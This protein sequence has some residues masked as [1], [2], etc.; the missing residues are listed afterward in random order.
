VFKLR[1]YQIKACERIWDAW[2]EG[3]RRPAVV[4]PTGA[5][6]TVTFVELI[7]QFVAGRT[8]SRAVV[9]VH[10]EE[11]AQQTV[12]KIRVMMPGV[13]VGVVKAD[14]DETHTRVV[15]CSTQTLARKGRVERLANVGLV[16]VDECHHYAAKTWKGVLERFGC[17][18][19]QGPVTVGFTATLSRGDNVGLGTV[20]EDVVHQRSI[21]AMIRDGHLC[22]LR[23]LSVEVDGLDLGTVARK[24]GGDFADGSLSDALEASGAA[25]VIADAYV[26]HAGNGKGIM[27]QGVV[28]TPTVKFARRMVDA[29][30][31]AGVS[32]AVITG[33]TSSEDRALIYKR[34]RE[35]DV[36][37]LCNCMVLTEGWDAPWAEVAVIARP[38]KS[39]GLYTQMVGRVL[40]THPGKAGALVLDVCG[41]AKNVSLCTVADLSEDLPEIE[42]GETIKE[43]IERLEKLANERP[44]IDPKRVVASEVD[45]FR[46]AQGN[47]L[48][49]R[50]GACFNQTKAHT[51]FLWPVKDADTYIVGRYRNKES[52]KATGEWLKD[53]RWERVHH[54]LATPYPMDFAVALTDDMAMDADP[55][56][57]GRDAPWRRKRQPPTEGQIRYASGLGYTIPPN[58]GADKKTVDGWTRGDVAQMISIA[59]VGND[60]HGRG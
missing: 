17:F 55:S 16:V 57:A 12:D 14:R 33:E 59:V 39:S 20:W 36:R 50:K 44:A 26:K 23:S 37:V 6:K 25:N 42:D 34:Y 2:K 27:R 24:S 13:S 11:L 49:T 5:G 22:D 7:R 28:F 9:L 29:F 47:W 53:G 3:L 8:T 38:T 31:E 45:L 19:P 4:L 41:S 30:E 48:K 35:G 32:A 1:D 56:I 18:E 40:R 21:L 10:R 51:Y 43:A 15:V 52:L 58:V 46:Q 54:S 60:L